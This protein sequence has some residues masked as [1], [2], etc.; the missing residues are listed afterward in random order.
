MVNM[1][2]NLTCL[3]RSE[4]SKDN[5]KVLVV[6]GEVVEEGLEDTNWAHQPGATRIKLTLISTVKQEETQFQRVKHLSL[7][8]IYGGWGGYALKQ[9]FSKCGPRTRTS[10]S[11]P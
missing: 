5:G 4:K 8:L 11:G 3:P 9:C 1:Y 10:S 7:G 6:K 2:S